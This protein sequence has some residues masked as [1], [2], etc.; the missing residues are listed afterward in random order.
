MENWERKL[1]QVNSPDSTVQSHRDKLRNK[2]KNAP[3][4]THARRK[5]SMI[6]LSLLLVVGFSGLTIAYPGWAEDVYQYVIV[7]KITLHTEDGTEIKIRTIQAEFE[8]GSVVCDSLMAKP[9][10]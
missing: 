10:R 4:T 5:I 6:T 7:R 9:A 2:L 3:A 8:P 1:N